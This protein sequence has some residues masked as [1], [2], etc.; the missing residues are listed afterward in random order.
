[1]KSYKDLPRE[2]VLNAPEGAMW[3]RACF[4]Y[5]YEN[6]EM[7][8]FAKGNWVLCDD[9]DLS[10]W[11]DESDF[12]PL[13]NVKIPWDAT[14]DS[15]CP[16]PKGTRTLLEFTDSADE[17]CYE[18]ELRYWHNFGNWVISYTIID[19]DYI[20]KES[21]DHENGTTRTI[22]STDEAGKIRDENIR[23]LRLIQDLEFLN[24][25][26]GKFP[27]IEGCAKAAMERLVEKWVG[28]EST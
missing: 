5:K 18:P 26:A 6:D 19:P 24:Y 8:C 10:N 20:R 22:I 21:A 27:L 16:V 11:I 7:R 23:D 2:V 17:E 12:V 13:P 1:M 9:H 15:V 14:D 3:V 25:I 28:N 4:Y